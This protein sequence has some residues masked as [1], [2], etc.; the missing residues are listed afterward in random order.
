MANK[1]NKTEL[2]TFAELGNIIDIN[3]KFNNLSHFLKTVIYELEGTDWEFVQ[4]FIPEKL[5]ILKI[6]D[7]IEEISINP[8]VPKRSIKKEPDTE[9]KIQTHYNSKTV[10]NFSKI[11]FPWQK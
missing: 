7:K 1:N 3:M 8:K 5:V 10:D 2:F 11:E 4:I 6:R 9:A